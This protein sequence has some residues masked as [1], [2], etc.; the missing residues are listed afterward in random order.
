MCSEKFCKILRKSDLRSSRPEVF[1]EKLYFEISQSSQESTCTRVSFLKKFNF[2]KKA[3]L[4]R[5]FSREFCE[6]SKN[7]FSTEHLQMTVSVIDRI[8]KPK[9][10]IITNVFKRSLKF[11]LRKSCPNTE[12]F[13]VR[14]FLYS[15]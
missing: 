1:C 9:M 11:S 12:L 10:A 8:N 7:T 5:V 13:L 6:I 2:I 4:A 3:T 15:D 14:I